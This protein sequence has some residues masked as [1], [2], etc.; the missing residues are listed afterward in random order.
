MDTF[1]NSE[2]P[3]E[4]NP[5][6]E[7]SFDAPQ[8]PQNEAPQEPRN[9]V[10]QEHAPEEL[11]FVVPEELRSAAPAG[12]RNSLRE[13]GYFLPDIRYLQRCPWWLPPSLFLSYSIRH[14]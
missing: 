6:P 9:E 12:R 4:N 14:I 10:P 2:Y 1:A 5:A 7:A 8:E 3:E 11:H 13:P